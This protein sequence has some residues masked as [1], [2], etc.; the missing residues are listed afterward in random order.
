MTS[1]A[2]FV[3]GGIQ[4][5]C[6][7]TCSI[8]LE[9][10]CAS[11]PSTSGYDQEE[12]DLFTVEDILVIYMHIPQYLKDPTSQGSFEAVEQ[13]R[14]LRVNTSRNANIFRHPAFSDF[15][16][17]HLRS[18]V[19]DADFED[20]IIQHLAVAAAVRRANRSRPSTPRKSERNEASQLFQDLQTQSSSSASGSTVMATSRLRIFTSDR[21]YSTLSSPENQDTAGPSEPQSDSL[22]ARLHAMSARYKESISKGARGW[23]EKFFCRSCS[24]SELGSEKRRREMNGEIASVSRLKEPLET[25]E[26]NKAEGTSLSSHMKDGSVGGASNQNDVDASGENSS[27]DDNIP[28]A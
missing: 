5:S 18:S 8:C 1:A 17:E 4:D 11:D 7:D 25:S 26:N 12:E 27:N 3:E 10:F 24:M 16:L 14:K 21:G 15:E 19:N 13:E 20:Q 28:S 2:A 9:E 22:R 23:R 6:G